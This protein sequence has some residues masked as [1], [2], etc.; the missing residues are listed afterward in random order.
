MD[1][2]W[3]YSDTYLDSTNKIIRPGKG[4]KIY[5]RD[6]CRY[7][8][9]TFGVGTAT[10]PVNKVGSSL[11]LNFLTLFAFFLQCDNFGLLQFVYNKTTD[12]KDK[13]G[14]SGYPPNMPDDEAL[15]R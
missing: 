3:E 11:D 7:T 10:E 4:T 6:I 2:I 12:W 8:T 9:H 14:G 5:W 13:E 15:L 1:T